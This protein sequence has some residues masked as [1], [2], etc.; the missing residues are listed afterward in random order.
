[1]YVGLCLHYSAKSEGVW[2]KLR[3]SKCVRVYPA[4]GELEHTE[5]AG[6]ALVE[7]AV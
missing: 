7:I 4:D 2:T 1:V 6:V 3:Q 5:V